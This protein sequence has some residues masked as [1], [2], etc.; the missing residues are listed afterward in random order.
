MVP[1]LQQQLQHALSTQ[2]PPVAGMEPARTI[3]ALL[4]GPSRAAAICKVRRIQ[5]WR[6]SAPRARGGSGGQIPQR[7]HRS[8]LRFAREHGIDLPM[9][10]LLPDVAE[11]EHSV[12]HAL[13]SAKEVSA[14]RN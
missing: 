1:Q 5:A 12:I 11:H 13:S 3:I 10:L 4:G 14:G 7:H 6:W 8:I 2:R 9:R